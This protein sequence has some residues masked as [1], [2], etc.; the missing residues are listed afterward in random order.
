MRT[1]KNLSATPIRLP[2]PGGKT[3]HLGP[4]M[5]GSVRDTAAEHPALKRMCE[6]GILELGDVATGGIASA[7]ASSMRGAGAHNSSGSRR[8]SGD[9]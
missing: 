1:V 3:L 7:A 5:T 4:G 9:R 8:Q 2:L 6:S